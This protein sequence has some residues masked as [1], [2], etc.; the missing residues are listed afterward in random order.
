[1]FELTLTLET[2]FY[3]MPLRLVISNKVNKCRLKQIRDSNKREVNLNYED[4]ERKLHLKSTPDLRDNTNYDNN[5]SNNISGLK[6]N[7]NLKKPHRIFTS[8]ASKINLQR[9]R[10]KSDKKQR[11]QSNPRPVISRPIPAESSQFNKPTQD[12]TSLQFANNIGPHKMNRQ[13]LSPL[14]TSQVPQIKLSN[15]RPV[16]MTGNEEV[17]IWTEK[18]MESV[19]PGS[20]TVSHFK[21]Q[22]CN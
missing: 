18:P 10:T 22:K 14:L 4:N 3:E 16:S 2:R 13:T 12:L 19:Q 21:F 17:G 9:P 11:S 20:K 8:A 6:P 5:K 15:L 7:V 1:M